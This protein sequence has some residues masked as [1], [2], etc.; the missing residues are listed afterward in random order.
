MDEDKTL[1]KTVTNRPLRCYMDRL[2]ADNPYDPWSL[3]SHDH[4]YGQVG[5]TIISCHIDIVNNFVCPSDHDQHFQSEL[6][7]TTG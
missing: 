4:C 2:R 7:V 3:C 5:Y 1:S 6:G